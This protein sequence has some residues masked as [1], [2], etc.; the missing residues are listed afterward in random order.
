[1]H[2]LGILCLSSHL[3]TRTPKPIPRSAYQHV[4]TYLCMYSM[5]NNIFT[6]IFFI[7]IRH[8]LAFKYLNCSVQTLS[9]QKP[10]SISLSGPL[11]RGPNSNGIQKPQFAEGLYFCAWNQRDQIWR[12]FGL[13]IGWFV[14]F[15]QLFKLQKSIARDF[16]Q[17]LR[18]LKI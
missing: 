10:S 11:R 6:I 13:R 12:I 17:K 1:M 9:L 15:G 2:V 18:S 7:W 4:C 5:S 3:L 16:G 14:Y 8:L